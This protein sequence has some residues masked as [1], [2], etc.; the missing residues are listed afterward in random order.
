MSLIIIIIKGRVKIALIDNHELLISA[1]EF[2]NWDLSCQKIV[3]HMSSKYELYP[4]GTDKIMAVSLTE[5]IVILYLS[6]QYN[7]YLYCFCSFLCFLHRL[8]IFQIRFLSLLDKHCLTRSLILC[9]YFFFFLA[10]CFPCF[11]LRHL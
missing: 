5:G 10:V 1:L 11:C 6:A 9:W 7:V 2:N 4:A 3:V 8:V